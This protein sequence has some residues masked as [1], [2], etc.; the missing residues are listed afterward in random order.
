MRRKAREVL[1]DRQTFP[2]GGGALGCQAPRLQIR[3]MD[4]KGAQVL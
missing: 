1:C 3:D 4:G 2:R